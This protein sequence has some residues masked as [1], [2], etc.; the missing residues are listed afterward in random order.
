MAITHQHSSRCKELFFVS[1]S[2]M[3]K[4]MRQLILDET[5]WFDT[6]DNETHPGLTGSLH[7]NMTDFVSLLVDVRF[8]YNP[9]RT[10]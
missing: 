5:L 3:L 10:T 4:A 8:W 2:D 6:I 1:E 7:A 9:S